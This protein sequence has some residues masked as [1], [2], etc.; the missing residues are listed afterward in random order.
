MRRL[1]R[2]GGMLFAL[3]LPVLDLA[4]AGNA[5]AQT[6]GGFTAAEVPTTGQ[7]YWTPERILSA[8]PPASTLPAGFAPAPLG[9]APSEAA[10][11]Q[12]GLGSSPTVEVAPQW[13]N[14]VH[15]PVALESLKSAPVAT[16]AALGGGVFTES[17]VIPP[18]TGQNNPAILAYPYR[19][20]GLLVAHDPRTGA[21][22]VCSAAVNS[23]RAI[24]TS[25]RCV[26]RGSA[27]P[28]QRY[29]YHDI[30]FIPAYDNGKAPYGTWSGSYVIV[31]NAWWL[32]G[33]LPNP[34]DFAFVEAADKN[35]KTLGSVVG[36]FGWQTGRLSHNHFTTLGYPCNLDDCLLMQRNDAQT[37]GFGGNN[38]W[39]EGSDMGLG[40]IGGPWVQDFGQAPKGA[41]A[42][43][44]GGN[45]IV[46]VTSYTPASGT[47]FLGASQFDQ[48]FVNMRHAFCAHKAGNC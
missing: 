12:G 39:T 27:N 3:I 4:S 37:S 28:G 19:A 36:A 15:P 8:A 38:T 33:T 48:T 17:R 46:G 45:V 6:T 32:T 25:A 34:A 40:V 43:P 5:A 24:L 22:I 1:L 16:N 2:I 11:S 26:S 47:G 30:S 23:R 13:N 31:S 9:A 14:F 18:S 35:G 41:P 42:V 21:V 10:T 29:L 20:V 7:S 44:F